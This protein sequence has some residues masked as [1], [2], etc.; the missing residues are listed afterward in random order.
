VIERAGRKYDSIVFL[1]LIVVVAVA[2]NYPGYLVAKT[3]LVHRMA[4]PF[5]LLVGL[6]GSVLR[7]R[8]FRV[9]GWLAIA[10]FFPAILF[11]VPYF[12]HMD[13]TFFGFPAFWRLATIL[14]L[15]GALVVSYKRL[16]YIN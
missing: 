13:P 9:L 11:S 1:T 3:T 8:L 12:D 2:L 6:I 7:I 14:I 10:W 5:L 4:D 15:S 16:A